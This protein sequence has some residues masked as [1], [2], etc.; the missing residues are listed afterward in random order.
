LSSSLLELRIKAFIEIAKGDCG[1]DMVGRVSDALLGAKISS[2]F[3]NSVVVFR[4]KLDEMRSMGEPCSFLP[5]WERWQIF[6]NLE[7]VIL[8]KETTDAS[9]L[10]VYYWLNLE[11]LI[12]DSC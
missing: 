4:N 8:S 11:N 5:D 3:W 7:F 6:L 1:A 12:S 10:S 9:S 2:S